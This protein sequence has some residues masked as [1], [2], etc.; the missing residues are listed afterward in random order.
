[1]WNIAFLLTM[2]YR[3]I[4]KSRYGRITPIVQMFI[5]NKNTR[6]LRF[7]LAI[8]WWPWLWHWPLTWQWTCPWPRPLR[9]NEVKFDFLNGN[10]HFLWRIWKD[11]KILRSICPWPWPWPWPR[12]E[13][14][15]LINF[16]IKNGGKFPKKCS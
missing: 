16:A 12:W 7:F 11:R 3:V 6:G 4:Q 8:Q 2:L 9:S 1:M 10:P 15:F 13:I 14:Y 5:W